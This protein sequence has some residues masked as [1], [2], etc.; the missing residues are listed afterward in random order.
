MDALAREAGT[1]VSAVMLGAI[2]GSGLFPFARED[3]EA[4]VRGGARRAEQPAW[5]R[6]ACAASR[7]PST[8]SSAPR[9]QA[10][11]RAGCYRTSG[12]DCAVRGRCSPLWRTTFPAAS[13]RHARARPCAPARLPGR[14][15]RRAL[16][17]APAHVLDAERAADPAGAHGFATTRET[18]RWLALWMAFDDIVRVADLKS[19]ASRCAARAARGQGRRR[20]PAARSTTTSSPACRSSPRCCRHRW[21]AALHALGPRARRQRAARPGRCR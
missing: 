3:Y 21:R 15:L 13:A 1:V 19:R 12:D 7:R 2:A 14:R 11:C 10:A 5:R 16:S 8:P 20:R 4:V 9:A 18:A 6:P 17:A